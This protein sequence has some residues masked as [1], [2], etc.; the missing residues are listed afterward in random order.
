MDIIEILAALTRGEHG[1]RRH[2]GSPGL[3]EQPIPLWPYLCFGQAA[4]GVDGFRLQKGRKQ[5]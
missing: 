3:T 2:R 4:V 1:N 5:Q